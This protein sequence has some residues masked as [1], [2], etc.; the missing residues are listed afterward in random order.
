L[1]VRKYVVLGRGCSK[2][3]RI[4]RGVI[5]ASHHE[6]GEYRLY[7]DSDPNCCH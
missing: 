6:L 1:L 2:T 4:R 7:C 5:Q 3:I